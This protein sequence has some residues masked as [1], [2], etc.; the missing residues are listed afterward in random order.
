[1][2]IPGYLTP[3]EIMVQFGWGRAQLSATARREGWARYRVG[4]AYLY[5]EQD[6][7]D[8]ALARNRTSLLKKAGWKLPP[9]LVRHDDW[10][11]DPGCP[12]CGLLAVL[13]PDESGWL[14]V[15]G[16]TGKI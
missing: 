1:M 8:F 16:H 10:D 6:I 13:T 7:A 9:G 5:D 14:C 11:L 15:Q 4:N 2:E 12:E 3:K